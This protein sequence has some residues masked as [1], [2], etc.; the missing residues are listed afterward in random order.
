MLFSRVRWETVVEPRK[1]EDLRLVG[2]VFGVWVLGGG[3]EPV[4]VMEV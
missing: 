3:G 2:G 1:R 4:R